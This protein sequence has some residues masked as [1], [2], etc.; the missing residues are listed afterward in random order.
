L[1][2]AC[3]FDSSAPYSKYGNAPVILNYFSVTPKLAPEQKA[4]K[5]PVLNAEQKTVVKN[6]FE[7]FKTHR[8]QIR[9]LQDLKAHVWVSHFPLVL[10]IG[11]EKTGLY[12]HTKELASVIT[13][14]ID[15]E[16]GLYVHSDTVCSPNR[17]KVD[18]ELEAIKAKYELYD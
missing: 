9:F 8:E 5:I 16:F 4:T 13:S 7:E 18:K 2:S 3:N 14:A 6:F 15:K 17:Q 10:L 11:K 12:H 1:S